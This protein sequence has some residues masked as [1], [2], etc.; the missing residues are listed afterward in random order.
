MPSTHPPVTRQPSLFQRTR[1]S[2]TG[3]DAFVAQ[4]NHS[5]WA[6]WTYLFLLAITFFIILLISAFSQQA[7][8]HIVQL[9]SE[10]TFDQL[11]HLQSLSCRCSRSS[12]P[13]SSFLTVSTRYHQV[14]S[15]DFTSS[16][17]RTLIASRGDETF[18]LLDQ[19]LLS[20]HFRMLSS[21]CTLS[22][23]TI[24]NAITAFV[25]STF[26]SVEALTRTQFNDQIDS[27]L[28]NLIE[29]T[30]INFGHPFTHIIDTLRANQ[31]THLFLSNWMIAFS[32]A[33]ENYILSNK[34]LSYNNGTCTCATPDGSSCW[35]PLTF[36]S[37][38]QTNLTLPGLRGG[39]LPVDGLRQSTLECLYDERCLAT[40][41][42][43]INTTFTPSI[44]APLD[45]KSI[46][47]FPPQ[48]T[49]LSVMIDQLF[50]EEWINTSNYSSYYQQCAP[51][52]CRY[53]LVEQETFLYIITSLLGL[54]GGVTLCLRMFVISAFK[55]IDWIKIWHRARNPTQN[56]PDGGSIDIS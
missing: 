13:Y 24:Q 52:D 47:R 23:E 12:T 48:S 55:L 30:P 39:C 8:V 22:S 9:P 28:T 33:T 14:C 25:S 5:L 6:T 45:Q 37:N 31:L 29:Q 50:V 42:S 40:I 44:P 20:N 35:W 56:M 15:S 51:R 10:S 38:N 18:F 32:S 46:T 54:Y 41:R 21:F 4:V 49:P 11:D 26:V 1:T 2:I 16:K 36:L 34:P 7:S 3:L 53:T 27:L 17:W 43:L 19:P